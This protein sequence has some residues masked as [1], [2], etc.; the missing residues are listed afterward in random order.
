MSPQRSS[1]RIHGLVGLMNRVRDQ[2]RAGVAP[3]DQDDLRQMVRDGTR[4]VERICREYNTSPASLPAPSRHAYEYLRGLD[5]DQLPG[6]EDGGPMGPI[7]V[8]GILATC[9]RYHR[10]FA[11]LVNSGG[12]A[13]GAEAPEVQR[14]ARRLASEAEAI[15]DLCADA[16]GTPSA[17]P[18]R[19]RRGYQWL[20]FLS[21]P[22][23]LTQHLDVLTHVTTAGRRLLERR[24]HPGAPLH[25]RLFATP[26]LYRTQLKGRAYHV[27]IN[28]GF[29]NASRSTLGTLMRAAL[30]QQESKSLRPALRAYAVSDAFAEIQAELQASTAAPPNAGKGQYHDL[31]EAFNRVNAAYFEGELK[32]PNLRWNRIPTFRKLGDYDEAGDSLMVSITLDSADVPSFVIDYVVYHELLHKTM[33]TRAINGRRYAHTRAFREAEQAFRRYE[34][35]QAVINSMLKASR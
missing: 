18:I 15:A 9:N 19:S 16:G 12:G 27:L 23:N 5:L 1:L 28:E 13:L 26:M 7:R 34:E 4:A 32:R 25:V 30:N 10:E 33:G 2:L 11:K 24:S 3:E 17:L 31:D 8:P 22:K 21:N 20:R 29:L 6:P 14:I 35:A